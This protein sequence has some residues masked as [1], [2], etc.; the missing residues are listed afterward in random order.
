MRSQVRVLLRPPTQKVLEKSR[1]FFFIC[2]LPRNVQNLTD[3]N[4]L[5]RGYLPRNQVSDLTPHIVDQFGAVRTGASA[6]V[7]VVQLGVAAVGVPK[8]N[9]CHTVRHYRQEAVFGSW[10]QGCLQKGVYP[11]AGGRHPHHRPSCGR[12]IPIE[13]GSEQLTISFLMGSKKFYKH[14]K[15]SPKCAIINYLLLLVFHMLK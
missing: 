10:L 14:W 8:V 7:R 11:D 9:P 2:I 15:F 5:H 13:I 12:Y 6:A 3:V 1:T 4:P